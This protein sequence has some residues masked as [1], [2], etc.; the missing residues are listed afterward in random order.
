MPLVIEV[1]AGLIRDERGRYLV[2]QRRKGSHLAGLWEFPGGKLEAGETPA[3]GLRRELTEELS[4]T[5]AVGELVETVRWE[6]PDRTVV[7]HF[8]DCRLQ[9]G[10]IVPTENQAMTWVPPEELPT[11]D[12]PPADQELIRRLGRRS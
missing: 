8:F 2:T 7:L 5:F 10:Q 9:S 11:Y 1:S 12:F 4:A 3:A 6:Y